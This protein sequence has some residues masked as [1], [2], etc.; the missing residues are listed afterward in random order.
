MIVS[1]NNIYLL[2]DLDDKVTEMKKSQEILL[3]SDL[4]VI[5]LCSKLGKLDFY[6]FYPILYIFCNINACNCKILLEANFL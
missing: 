5:S 6:T 3:C 2:S 4:V 1:L